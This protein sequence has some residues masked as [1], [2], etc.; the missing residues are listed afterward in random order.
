M[1]KAANVE[2]AGP[3]TQV[4]NAL[5]TGGCRRRCRGG[6]G[7]NGR[8]GASDQGDQGRTGQCSRHCA[9]AFRCGSGAAE[10]TGREVSEW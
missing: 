10:K 5:V 8:R 4:G 1:L 7:G 9:T 6:E 2:L 3:M